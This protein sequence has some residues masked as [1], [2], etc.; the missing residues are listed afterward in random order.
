[1]LRGEPSA[2]IGADDELPL[3][4]STTTAQVAAVPFEKQTQRR[5]AVG[6]GLGGIL[7]AA[8]DDNKCGVD[9]Q[10]MDRGLIPSHPKY[11]RRREVSKIGEFVERMPQEKRHLFP[12]LQEGVE[13]TAVFC[14]HF[15][16]VWNVETGASIRDLS[17]NKFVRDR[18]VAIL[19]E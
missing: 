6:L 16:R 3:M 11:I 2:G 13:E 9:E 7:D 19:V 1:L 17:R 4:Q 12:L 14:R 10:R 18:L 15:F 5:F 8:V